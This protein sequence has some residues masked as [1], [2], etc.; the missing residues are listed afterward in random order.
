MKL[1]AV[2]MNNPDR[3]RRDWRDGTHSPLGKQPK[4]P[5]QG[6]RNH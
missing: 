6:S 1:N 4:N 2:R 5:T 3:D